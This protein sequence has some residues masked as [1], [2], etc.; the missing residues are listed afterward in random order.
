M[1]IFLHLSKIFNWLTIACLTL[2]MVVLQSNNSYAQVEAGTYS[3]GTGGDWESLTAAFD[4]LKSDSVN[5]NII[6]ELVSPY[7]DTDLS[8]E[9]VGFDSATVTIRPQVD[10]SLVLFEGRTHF[11]GG[12]RNLIFDGRPG[13]TGDAFPDGNAIMIFRQSDNGNGNGA[14]HQQG[15]G[16]LS[17]KFAEIRSDAR[18]GIFSQFSNGSN[19]ALGAPTLTV[20][21][22]RITSFQTGYVES[23]A[24][25]YYYTEA[26][27]TLFTAGDIVIK[28]NTIEGWKAAPGEE[29]GGIFMLHPNSNNADGDPLKWSIVN[30]HVSLER[31][32]EQ[33][34]VT[35]IRLNTSNGWTR[36]GNEYEVLHNTVVLSGTN[37]NVE[38]GAISAAFARQ[39]NATHRSHK[40]TVKNN[41]FENRVTNEAGATAPLPAVW[42]RDDGGDVLQNSDID[43][44]NYTSTS[45]TLVAYGNPSDVATSYDALADWTASVPDSISGRDVNTTFEMPEFT[46]FENGDLSLVVPE[47]GSET[48][49]VGTP[50][51]IQFD[52]KGNNRKSSVPSK[53]AYEVILPGLPAGAY[54]IA[55]DPANPGDAD[56]ASL[57]DAFA[58][59]EIK[60]LEGEVFLELESGYTATNL[61]LRGSGVEEFPTTIRPA[62]GSAFALF[63]GRTHVT[64][65]AENIIFDGRPGGTGDAFP[66]GNAVMIFR[67]EDNS[68]GNGAIHHQGAGALT[69]KYVEIRSDARHGI[70][71][72]FA[73]TLTIK[74]C[75]I[76]SFQSGYV[77]PAA[78]AYYYT[79]AIR[80]LFT[81]GDITIHNNTIEGWLSSPGEEVG[82]IFML[83]PNS[84]NANGDPLKWSIVNNHISLERP[85]EQIFV[86]AVRINTS[87]G[88][89]R[90]G[91][92][93]EVLHN[94]VVLS[95]TSSTT[96]GN[97]ISCA[98]A[99]QAN[100]A[101]REHSMVIKNNI[102]DNRVTNVDGGTAPLPALW[103]RDD[104]E[105][106]LGL[107]EIDYNNYSSASGDLVVYGN[108]SADPSVYSDLAT[109]QS[110]S[111]L[112]AST[113]TTTP[114]FADGDLSIDIESVTEEDTWYKAPAIAEITQDILGAARGTEEVTKGAYELNPTA[115]SLND[116]LDVTSSVML[117]PNPAAG[118]EL[119]LYMDNDIQGDLRVVILSVEGKELISKDFAKKGNVFSTKLSTV[120][121][122]KGLYFMHIYSQ[123]HRAAKRFIKL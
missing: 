109:W 16:S 56:Y 55:A 123:D 112:D 85:T 9:G 121:L 78:D 13:G 4:Q 18:H 105:D 8:I 62:A 111:S 114:T 97:A 94:T 51:G 115:L 57:E 21:G 7:T 119:S 6:L 25:A 86:T 96:A 88:W 46:D 60:G 11:T 52:I 77:E 72:Q 44:N 75:R 41:I 83:H 102:F 71:S 22:C 50:L 90:E 74:N 110:A 19:S 26:I 91:N 36:E 28:G 79:E 101:H 58:D 1:K 17:V 95:G 73:N 69:V 80:T 84:N 118:A 2:F 15:A 35:A 3:V 48:W 32:A 122:P 20:E 89:T 100:A 76:S 30:N 99:R 104:A 37:S 107:S 64:G 70:F 108:P 93:Y 117:Y 98:F 53:G 67:Q 5:G 45:G 59:I 34:F 23:D 106:V 12:S 47:D 116:L 40:M 42:I 87:N 66:D 68:N 14:I 63:S 10:A 33:F 81:Q 31:P 43:F 113:T 29:V 49:Y 38:A 27:R 82:A 61:T 120:S 54:S 92:E 65:G 39:A 24:E 103:I